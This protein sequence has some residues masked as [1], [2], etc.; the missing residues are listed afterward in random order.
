MSE[1]LRLHLVVDGYGCDF[2]KPC[3]EG[4]VRRFSV[5]SP[6]NPG[7]VIGIVDAWPGL[8]AIGAQGA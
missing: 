6:V 5:E 7:V 8:R 4:F 3:N 2:S 1:T